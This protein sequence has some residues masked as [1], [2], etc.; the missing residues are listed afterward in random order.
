MTKIYFTLSFIFSLLFYMSTESQVLTKKSN[1]K[2]ML[3]VHGKEYKVKG[4]TFGYDKNVKN[5]DDHFKELKFLGVNTIRTWAS[6]KNTKELLD[7]AHRNG[8]K[9]MVGIWMRHGR[10]GM[11]DDDSFDYLKD[12]KG[13]ESMYNNA[14]KVVESFKEHPA[15]LTWGIGNEVYLNMTTDEEKIAYSNLLERIC[16]DIKKIDRNHP[17][18]SVEAW[19]FGLEW[20]QKY[21]PSIDIYGLN[22]YGQGA[23]LLSSELGKR[24]IDK[25]YVVT[26]FGVTG[27]WDIK[28][29]TNGVKNEP[30]DSEKYTAIVKGYSN[31]IKNKPNN[32]GVFVFHYASGNEFIAPWLFTHYNKLKRPQ[33][34]AVRE[35]FTGNLPINYVPK[36]RDF[37]IEGSSFD[38]ESWIPINLDVSDSENDSLTVSFGYNQ[39]TGSRK[40]RDQ[41]KAL[42]QRG[43]F[44]E[45]FEIKLPKENGAV[46]VYIMIKDSYN[47][48]A[49]AS[50]GIKISDKEAA[51][52]KFLVPKA[53]LPFYVYKNGVMSPYSPSAY[54]GNHKKM[55]VDMEYTEKFG[56]RRTCL[57]LSYHQPY[58][59]FG[60]GLV[61][62]ANDWGDILGGYDISGAKKFSFW[63]RANKKDVRATIGF[64]LIGKD[65]KYPDTAKKSKEVKLTTKWKKY[66]FSIRKLDLSCI[67]SGLTVFSSG[68]GDT[69]E[70]FLDD[71]V[72]E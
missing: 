72:F 13:K 34:W 67:R 50:T 68:S 57:K 14:I 42:N 55:K 56:P 5:Y 59:W 29:E 71:V 61:D 38:S 23:A 41:I 3:S 18:T 15:V 51:K 9:V 53:E 52:R 7:A 46:K 45:G 47:N 10:P 36:I 35:A 60:L 22:C 26:E 69:I 70:I 31:W 17:I 27:E 4:V 24:N 54:M 25:P 64:G 66:S 8:V 40:R 43:S 19:T 39:R 2:W 16:G 63:A 49:I 21:V 6:G 12:T 11:E 58:D 44:K 20:W 1:G 32:L 48:L 28:N 30:S 65:K 62:P 33:Y 37:K